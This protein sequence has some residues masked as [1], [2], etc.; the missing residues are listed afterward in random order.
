MLPEATSYQKPGGAHVKNL[1]SNPDPLCRAARGQ[2][3]LL[4]SSLPSSLPLQ[5]KNHPLSPTHSSWDSP[6]FHIAVFWLCSNHW[7]TVIKL[8]LMMKNLVIIMLLGFCQNVPGIYARKQQSA[9]AKQMGIFL[10]L[11]F[12]MLGTSAVITDLISKPFQCDPECFSHSPS[13]RDWQT[14]R[15]WVSD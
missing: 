14:L 13:F 15:L 6:H 7:L 12:I 4:R 11:S 1:M 8:E 9:S 2:Q 5:E 10:F 3:A